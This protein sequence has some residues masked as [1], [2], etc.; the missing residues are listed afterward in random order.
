MTAM[1][2][3]AGMPQQQLMYYYVAVPGP[4]GQQYGVQ[5]QDGGVN[6]QFDGTQPVPTFAMPPQ[7]GYGYPDQA[8]PMSHMQPAMMPAGQAGNMVPGQMM[9]V[10]TMLPQQAGPTA[11]A[12]EQSQDASV[13][14]NTGWG[15]SMPPQQGLQGGHDQQTAASQ[16]Q[17][18]TRSQQNS[19]AFKIVD[20][21]TKTEVK[22]S[23]RGGPDGQAAPV[24]Q[25]MSPGHGSQHQQQQPHIAGPG[26][27]GMQQPPPVWGQQPPP[28]QFG[29]PQLSQMQHAQQMQ[30]PHQPQPP[31]QQQQA[32]TGPAGAAASAAKPEKKRMGLKNLKLDKGGTIAKDPGATAASGSAAPGDD[33]ASG[34]SPGTAPGSVAPSPAPS[35]EAPSRKPAA[36]GGSGDGAAA[37]GAAGTTPASTGAGG[38]GSNTSATAQLS[39]WPPA[40]GQPSNFASSIKALNLEPM[41]AN[42]QPY[43][44]RQPL[45][46][47]HPQPL[48]GPGHA[49]QQQQQPAQEQTLRSQQQEPQR[50]PP[51]SQQQSPQMP[52]SSPQMAHQSPQ[53]PQSSPQMPQQS[54]QLPQ[55]S[56]QM[57]QQQM[58]QQQPQYPHAQYQQMQMSQQQLSQQPHNMHQ[59]MVH[60]MHPMAPVMMQQS[61]VPVQ[62]IPSQPAA[63]PAPRGPKGVKLKNA[64]LAKLPTKPRDDAAD[65]KT[66]DDRP[67]ESMEPS[68]EALSE[69]A[70]S[71]VEELKA[72]EPKV[73][74]VTPVAVQAE[75][76]P[77]APIE[78]AESQAPVAVEAP[79]SRLSLKPENRVFDRTLMLRIWR[80]HQGQV[81][82]TVRGLQTNSRP[83]DAK[84]GQPPGTPVEQRNR[85]LRNKLRD[86]TQ[87]SG[88]DAKKKKELLK[89][90]DNAYKITQP[91]KREDE[92]ERRVRGL[93]N[94]IC[95]DNLKI[96][97]E[98]LALIEL[99]KAEELEFVIRIIFGKAL[100]DSHY[101]ET[102]ADM[103]FALR[104]R[105][106]E[107]P[108]ESEGEKAQTFTRVL[109]NTC[110][111]EFESLPTSFEPTEEEKVRIPADD[112]RLE[113]K[114]RKDKM[115]ANMKFIGNLFLR[116]LLAVKVIGQVVHDLIGIKETLPEE[117]MIECVCE[118]LQAI[119]HTLDG[120]PSGKML[121]LQFSARLMDLKRSNLPDGRAAFSKRIQFQIQDLLDLRQNNWQK[122]MFKEAAKTKDEV[123]KDAIAEAR[124]QAKGG[125]TEVMF[126]TQTVGVRPA[127]IDEFKA[128]KP[129]RPK[130]P[131]GPT[132]P[133]WDQVYVR[134]VFHYYC[135]DLNGQELVNNWNKAQPTPKDAKQGIEWLMDIGINDKTKE[136]IISEVI[137]EFVARRAVTWEVLTDALCPFLEGIED[138]KMDVP[139]C[140]V[141]FHS[142]L[143]R[144][145]LQSSV[146]FNCLILKE[147]PMATESSCDFTFRL[148][149]GGL[150]KVKDKGGVQAVQ[151]ALDIREFSEFA[152]KARKCPAGELKRHLQEEGLL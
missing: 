146:P 37:S 114:K 46:Q 136:E 12:L 70:T 33:A 66:T 6:Q 78:V 108:P 69:A 35:P 29:G 107:F 59:N 130:A 99:H 26:P 44:T 143:A 7:G 151:K 123:R 14:S 150:K 86:E 104:T 4:G 21:V 25:Q 30:P 63:A 36:S 74:E 10:T 119:G 41:R 131:E 18:S 109:L 52:Q 5:G 48:D 31:P 76:T 13:Q 20:P 133:A 89:T 101:C 27:A 71:G 22:P 40:G 115:L 57:P 79:R 91:T 134:K 42:P 72:E 122:K 81:H 60:S 106:P 73:A 11:Q 2:N 124:K 38:G 118:L 67:Q 90:S 152:C 144:L 77:D 28:Q 65:G 51:Q 82:H 92:L 120:T 32:Q 24:G 149:C 3:N 103:V 148:L 85:N 116:Q 61:M 39:R 96:I 125:G 127:Y 64:A 147:L 113:M 135:E 94:K 138:M 145:L 50:P 132:K 105:Y 98:R 16:Q 102:Y 8:V 111:N 110:Q 19:R 47:Q 9:L 75:A 128:V 139:H 83:G 95:P 62:Q 54:P 45:R 97:V 140:D 80:S 23:E 121:M 1:A 88:M 141:F 137:T 58:Q 129:Q 126:Q 93:L 55:Q 117:H 100:A 17:S 84:G 15:N 87:A 112:L 68:K 34:R 142:L 56:P 49:S 43:R 53:M